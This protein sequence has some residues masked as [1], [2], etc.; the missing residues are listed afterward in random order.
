MM[1]EAP[2]FQEWAETPCQTCK[3]PRQ[4]HIQPSDPQYCGI[5]GSGRCKDFVEPNVVV[6]PL[7]VGTAPAPQQTQTPTPTL[8]KTGWSRLRLAFVST[9]T[10]ITAALLGVTYRLLFMEASRLE[11]KLM[12]AITLIAAVFLATLA[13]IT[14]APS[15][16]PKP[17]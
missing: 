11:F 1:S 4:A 6:R 2:S 16:E 17:D 9:E 13:G 14:A 5:C 8:A 12:G 3:H 15:R 7:G 10:L